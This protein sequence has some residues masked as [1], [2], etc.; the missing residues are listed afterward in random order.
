MQLNKDYESEINLRDLFFYVLYRWRSILIVALLAT[1]LLGGYKYFSLRDVLHS[2]YSSEEEQAY[3]ERLNAQRE[4]VHRKEKQNNDLEAYRKESV[5]FQLNPQAIWTATCKYLVEV[6]PAA[7]HHLSEDITQDPADSILAAYT[8]PFADIPDDELTALFEG[9]R[10]EYIHELVE[11]VTDPSENTVTIRFKGSTKEFAGKGLDFFKNRINTTR[12]K[13][14]RIEVHTLSVIGEETILTADKDLLEKQID[15]NNIISINKQ[16]LSEAYL[17]LNELEVEGKPQNARTQLVKFIIIGFAVGLILMIVLYT[18][19][20]VCRS[21]LTESRELSEQY[22]LPLLGE[23]YRS[24]SIHKNKGLDSII[25]KWE[26]GTKT[27]DDETTYDN[28]SAIIQTK[29]DIHRIALVSTL[30]AENLKSVKEAL[31]ERIPEKG[32]ETIGKFLTNGKS[33]A[34]MSKAEAMILI[35]KKQETRRKD[36]ERM[37]DILLVSNADVIGVIVL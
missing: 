17:R 6:D 34:E 23:F 35:E 37:A 5:Y 14:Q 21:R 19:R 7:I 32:I 31:T 1:I 24:G 8:M 3:E 9:I 11:I 33:V 13:A 12:D 20:Y 2:S 16:N 18:F 22:T 36:I 4:F 30:N 25:A 27:V 15:L 29:Q 26:L 28:I 10:P